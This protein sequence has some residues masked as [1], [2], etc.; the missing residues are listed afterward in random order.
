M[1]TI[2]LQGTLELSLLQIAYLID[3]GVTAPIALSTLFGNGVWFTLLTGETLPE[4]A[5][6]RTLLGSLWGALLVCLVAGVLFPVAMLPVLFLQF[7]YKGL[8]LLLF[9]LPRWMAGRF[10]DVPV[11]MSGLF[12]GYLLAYPWVIPWEKLWHLAG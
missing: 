1:R 11:R 5:D 8:W 2:S 7:V 6:V 9:A 12:A 3:A 10:A 4:N